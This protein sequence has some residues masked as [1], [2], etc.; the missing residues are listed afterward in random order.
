MIRIFLAA[1]LTGFLAA[2]APCMAG[3]TPKP[4][5]TIG[6]LTLTAPWIRATPKGADVAG[7]Y[8]SITNTGAAAD[9]LVSGA[10]PAARKLELHEMASANGVMQMRELTQGL[11]I[12]PGETVE[13]KPGGLHIMLTGLGAPVKQGDKIKATLV[14]EKAGALEIEFTAAPVG[15]TAPASGH[16]HAH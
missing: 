15:A 13:F 4:A 7:G 5:Y 6:A 2:A 14:F 9:R 3:D 12:K 10:T 11:E 1:L 8:V 16:E